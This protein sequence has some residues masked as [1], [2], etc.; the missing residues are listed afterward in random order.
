MRKVLVSLMLLSLVP[1]LAGAAVTNPEGFEGYALT[2]SWNPTVAGEGWEVYGE[3]GPPAEGNSVHIATGSLAGNTTQVL[4]VDSSANGENLSAVWHASVADAAVPITR[5]SFEM[6]PTEILFGSEYRFGAM[7]LGT[8]ATW[9]GYYTWALFVGYGSW[10]G[11]GPGLPAG[12]FR[13]YVSGNEGENPVFNVV[14]FTPSIEAFEPGNGMWWAI[15]VEEDNG[16]SGVG[17]GQSSRVRMYD[18]STS[19]GAE[20]G[21]TAWTPHNAN[22]ENGTDFANGGKV[23]TFTNGVGEW[24]NFSMTE[25]PVAACNPG[26]ANN[27]L[28][29]SADDYA[30]VQGAFGNTGAVGIPGDANCDG[31]VSADDYASVQGNFGTTYGGAPIPEPTTIGL[32]AMGMIAIIRKRK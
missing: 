31:L 10:W 17:N 28:L 14:D 3:T 13:T 12:T 7:R 26:D 16:P 5:T 1:A 21:W 20:D 4:K 30:S 24:D 23:L 8:D 19:P 18:K 2:T 22:G 27:D 6:S 11:D 29:V 9:N 15:E 25:E 32:L